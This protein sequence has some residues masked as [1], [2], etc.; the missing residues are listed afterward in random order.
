M[1]PVVTANPILSLIGAFNIG[2]QGIATSISRYF[3]DLDPVQQ[4]YYTIGAPVVET[5]DFE[6]SFDIVIPATSTGR[7]IIASGL[8]GNNNSIVL[9]VF[10]SSVRAFAYIGTSITT[11]LERNFVRDG[12]LQHVSL[13]FTGTTITLSLNGGTLSTSTWLLDGNQD[14]ALIGTRLGTHFNGIIANVDLGNGNK[15]ALDKDGATTTEQAVN[16]NNLLTR[17]NVSAGDVELFTLNTATNPDQWE[18]FNQ[19][20]II[21]VAP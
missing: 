1:Y 10:G 17:V 11:I 12:T 20:V 8:L 15:W 6:W 18:N 21:P 3:A 14:I 5:G 2:A 7:Q 13:G 4:G 9:D 19:T 16:G